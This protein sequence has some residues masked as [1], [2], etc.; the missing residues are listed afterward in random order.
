M[1]NLLIIGPAHPL[2]GGLAT[3]DERL[4]REFQSMGWDVEIYTFSLQYPGFLFPGKT[5]YSNAP[6]PTDLDIHVCINSINPLNW[7]KVGLK[8]KR[9]NADLVLTRYWI[10]FMAPCLGTLLRIIKG[11]K[12]SKMV[13]LVDNVVPHEKR[14][15]D[16]IL[17]RFFINIPEWFI[18]M[19]ERV[20]EEL[21]TFRP[22][23]RSL[24]I[25]HPLYDVFGPVIS[26]E[27][28]R[29]HL[30]LPPNEKVILFFGFIRKYKGL[31][32]LIE[33]MGKYMPDL[34]QTTVLVAGEFYEPEE[35]YIHLIEEYK[36]QNCFRIHSDFIADEEVKYYFCACDLVVQPYKTASQSGVTPLAYYFEKPMVVTNVGA[37]PRLVPEGKAGF[38]CEAKPSS[39]AG[40]I[41]EFFR[42]DPQIFWEFI[43]KEKVKLSWSN[44]AAQIAGL[45]K[46]EA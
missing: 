4:A 44:F 27:E 8:L 30:N 14:M 38:I 36:L 46:A 13:C 3:F 1:P 34:H 41:Q 12:K 45:L 42:S 26:K 35:P 23:A 7:I 24:L 10:P 11:N 19:S 28:A 17:T 21:K 31:D 25:D 22:Q 37:L 20:E 9:K 40:R 2:R 6:K 15:G 5:Q 33:A 32:L 43:K 18:C 39:I 29:K 16:S